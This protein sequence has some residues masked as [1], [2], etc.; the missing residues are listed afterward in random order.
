MA[1]LSL[2][3]SFNNSFWSQDYRRGIQVLFNKLE[4]GVE[5]NREVA[6]FVRARAT[7][8]SHLA[9]A[10]ARAG[11]VERSSDRGFNTDDGASLL[12]AFRGLQTESNAQAKAHETVAH[13]LQTLVAGPFE[14]WANGYAV[15]LRD[16]NATVLNEYLR[17]YENAWHEV[18]K[19]KSK[20]IAKTRRADEL[21]DDANFAPA[22]ARPT[23]PDKYTMS[24]RVNPVDGPA[25]LGHGRGPSISRTPITAPQR[26]ASVSD[27]IAQRLREIQK[28]AS[29]SIAA[30]ASPFAQS[31]PLPAEEQPL[32]STGDEHSISRLDKGKGREVLD[33]PSSM[34]SPLPPPAVLPPDPSQSRPTI[35]QSPRAASLPSSGSAGT[36]E[37]AGTPV[38]HEPSS[39]PTLAPLTVADYAVP[40]SLVSAMLL[41]ASRE[42]KMRPVR[43][44]LLGEYSDCFT[45]DEFATWLVHNLPYVLTQSGVTYVPSEGRSSSAEKSKAAGTN[46]NSLR[47]N[48]TWANEK[49]D[50]PEEEKENVLP[51]N[52]EAPDVFQ[53]A[54]DLTERH[55]LLRRV[56]EFGN[57][58]EDADDAWYVFRPK[59]TSKPAL[60]HKLIGA[61]VR[62]NTSIVNAT[63]SVDSPIAKRT[64][65]LVNIVSQAMSSLNTGAGH[66]LPHVRARQEAVEAD[67][68]YRIAVRKLDRQ[69]LG[70]EEHLEEA[71]KVLQRWE[72]E[73]LRAVKTVLLQ[74]QGTLSNLPKALESSIERSGK[75]V[76]AY[77]PEVD[78]TALVERYRTGPF[79]PDPQVYQSLIHEEGDV[80]F[81]LDL[82]KWA[83]FD[84]TALTAGTSSSTELVP[85]VLS[86]LLEG[87]Q[88]AYARLPNDNEKRKS[89]VYEVPLPVVHRL[90]EALNA[91]PLPTESLSPTPPVMS[92]PGK[93]DVT[94]TDV[95]ARYASILAQFDAPVIASTIKLWLLELD[96]PVGL[97]EGWEEFRRLYPTVGGRGIK[98][99]AAATAT[100]GEQ[101]TKSPT[102]S[103][104]EQLEE[105]IQALQNALV[106]LP[107]VHLYVLD[108]VVSHLRTL[109]DTTTT[110]ESDEVYLTKLALSVGRTIIHPKVETEISIQ[111]RHSTLLF[112]DLVKHYSAILPPTIECKKRESVRKIPLRKRTLLVDARQSRSKI[113]VGGSR[114][115]LAA[116]GL[117]V[118]ARDKNPP[119]PRKE[120]TPP[121]PPLPEAVTATKTEETVSLSPQSAFKEPAP[122]IDDAPPRPMFKEPLP[123]GDDLP[124][125]PAF[126]EPPPELDDLPPRPMFKDPPPELDDAAPPMP[127]FVDPPSEDSDTPGLPPPSPH[128]ATSPSTNIVPP[129]PTK[130]ETERSLQSSPNSPTSSED[131]PLN[132]GRATISRVTSGGVRV[133]RPSGG[134][135]PRAGG[136][137]SVSSMVQQINQNTTTSSPVSP[138][139]LKRSSRAIS[140]DKLPGG[141]TRLT[142]GSKGSTKRFSGT[143][144]NGSG[145]RPS[146]VLGRS[147]AFARRTMA[148]DAEDA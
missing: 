61:G 125:R 10:L 94:T 147:S 65:N 6:D 99:S 26:S 73:R 117:P 83:E 59:V 114:V 63:G 132:P 110:E 144:S 142:R 100:D 42:L 25:L 58:F 89:W 11:Q 30:A 101:A 15:R 57:E 137:G 18:E 33:S 113:S 80:V 41:K 90:R 3:L 93:S 55:G 48:S 14:D 37:V 66:E 103:E 1:V 92:S 52:A 95:T 123:D 69:R 139:H 54:C 71:Y 86:A 146:S 23:S 115:E 135:H 136:G 47:K 107:R 102:N 53:F 17:S 84:W 126:K 104:E 82:R 22:P 60:T 45:G 88:N 98:L 2:P 143:S 70:L 145:S 79:R 4:Q 5:E 85:H 13:E 49:S 34:T 38:V 39:E 120:S 140:P 97:Y 122:Y 50:A 40:P 64:N 36:F 9:A 12:M 121:L 129:T 109:I 141:A 28:K 51:P 133:L 75:F 148:S 27:R 112:I 106:K 81:G 118:A 105:H 35:S 24:P 72:I 124:R 134:R 130:Q 128:S 127:K 8:E 96:P 108:K 32:F 43:V 19:L 91:V 29:N 111:D 20:S 62:L 138:T 78:L 31:Q 68:A 67:K 76:A 74:Y 46:E 16:C 44:P 7:A 116:M 56:G 77:Q 21:E 119:P 131:K 87:I